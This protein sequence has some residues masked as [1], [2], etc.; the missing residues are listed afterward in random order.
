[1][2]KDRIKHEYGLLKALVNALAY[3]E[4]DV[5]MK[6]FS[7]MRGGESI[8]VMIQSLQ[9][10]GLGGAE[11]I[12]QP[13]LKIEPPFYSSVSSEMYR[14]TPL[15][16]SLTVNPT[17]ENHINSNHQRSTEMTTESNQIA[18]DTFFDSAQFADPSTVLTNGVIFETAQIADCIVTY[19]HTGFKERSTYDT[20]FQSFR[21]RSSAGWP[22]HM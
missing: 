12:D 18:T 11:H 4:E 2:Q 21:S 17:F 13:E 15:Q 19:S 7:R 8:Q 6:L 9:S 14:L 1:M 3:S 10:P 5:A 20:S 16:Q 22:L